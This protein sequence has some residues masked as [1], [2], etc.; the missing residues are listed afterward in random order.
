MEVKRKGMPYGQL[1]KI[2]VFTLQL[3]TLFKGAAYMFSTNG[4]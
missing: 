4:Y 2:K 3:Q 1:F